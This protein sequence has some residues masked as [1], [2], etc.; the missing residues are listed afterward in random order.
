V[1]E[2]FDVVPVNENIPQTNDGTQPWNRHPIVSIPFLQMRPAFQRGIRH[3][4]QAAYFE[5]DNQSY[6]VALQKTFTYSCTTRSGPWGPIVTPSVF[7]VPQNVVATY[8]ILLKWLETKLNASPFFGKNQPKIQIVH[9]RWIGFQKHLSNTTQYLIS[10]E[11]ILYRQGKFQGKHVSFSV[12]VEFK[13]K[14]APIFTVTQT[15]V[16]GVVAEDKIGMFPVIATEDVAVSGDDY[17]PVP[18]DPLI[19]YPGELIDAKTIDTVVNEQKNKLNRSIA[20]QL[21]LI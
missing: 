15:R 18:N 11:T 10:I 16:E 13:P 17:L 14:K 2:G 6:D 21:F 1:Q 4:T 19:P 3:H 7:S 5:I 12:M 8:P 9:D 20:S